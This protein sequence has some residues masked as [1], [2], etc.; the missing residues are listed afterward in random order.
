M[1]HS[2]LTVRAVLYLALLLF[3]ALF[4]IPFY[5]VLVTSFKDVAELRRGNMLSLPETWTVAAWLKAW[6]AAC[7]GAACNGLRPYFYNSLEMVVP[8]VL[9]SSVIGAFNGYALAQWHFRGADAI[10]TLLLLGFFIP[11]QAILLPAAQ[12]LG[13]LHLSNTIAGLVL[14]HVA[15][16]IAFTTMLFRNYYV[17]VPPDLVRAARV[18]GAGFFLIF[19][20]IFLPI[21]LPIFTVCIIWQFTQIWND[22]LFGAAFSG[23]TAR[24]VTVGLNNLVNTTEGVKEYNVDMAGA[25]ITALPTL[26]VYIF[27]GRY[28]VRGL[29]AGAVKG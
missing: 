26:I 25:V 11:Y 12:F 22:F 28:F 13:Y 20:K 15:Y 3:A 18:D 19:R 17:S 29:T 2:S 1:Q 5:L 14:I 7:T 8:A 6:S 27:G 24:P 9:I 23:T 21:S 10:F 4:L 16:G